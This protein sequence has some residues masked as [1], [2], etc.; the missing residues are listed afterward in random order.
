M[1]RL[2]AGPPATSN[3]WDLLARTVQLRE[4]FKKGREPT[5]HRATMSGEHKLLPESDMLGSP[6]KTRAANDG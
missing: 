3:T 6:R 1:L 2:L 5:K 4:A